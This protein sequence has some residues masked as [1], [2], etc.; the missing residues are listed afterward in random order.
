MIAKKVVWISDMY[1][2]SGVG[3]GIEDLEERFIYASPEIVDFHD[4]RQGDNI[5]ILRPFR[6]LPKKTEIVEDRSLKYQKEKERRLS[7]L[8]LLDKS[9][10]KGVE[11]FVLCSEITFYCYRDLK[12]SSSSRNLHTKHLSARI[13]DISDGWHSFGK[14]LL[15][16]C[17]K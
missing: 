4:I 17:G 13:Y 12:L 9:E 2:K 10:R 16:L 14:D 8:E 6:L 11:V 15:E 1:G 3:T 5:I 7:L